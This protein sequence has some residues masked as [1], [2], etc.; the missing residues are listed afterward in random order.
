MSFHHS[1]AV[2]MSSIVYRRTADPAIALLAYDILT[3]QQAQIGIMSG[4][5]N[6]WELSSTGS[7]ERMEWMGH[8][9]GGPMPG[10]ASKEEIASLETLPVEEM[11]RLFLQLMIT[12]HKGAADMALF[13][14]TNAEEPY[15]RSVARSMAETQ[16]YEV[17]TM[18]QMLAERQ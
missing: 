11:D 10:M 2:E 5:L 16:Q 15:V 7:G 14:A 3:T 1:Q 8:G 9:M 18:E 13:A 4:W 12:H 6:V 17:G